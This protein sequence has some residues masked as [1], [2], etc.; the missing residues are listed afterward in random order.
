M[1]I[2]TVRK[3]VE[4]H[5]A[6]RSLFGSR[7]AAYPGKIQL[8][9]HLCLGPFRV[10][11]SR[12]QQILMPEVHTADDSPQPCRVDT[13]CAGPSVRFSFL[14]MVRRGSRPVSENSIFPFPGLARGEALVHLYVGP[15]RIK[16]LTL[17]VPSIKWFK[18]RVRL[19][20]KP[21]LSI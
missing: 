17:S 19:T 15:G 10:V 6:G 20:S 12:D 8:H 1:S 9:P 14:R 7:T 2:A 3:W 4:D 21:L 16:D 5:E 13:V 18:F 11:L